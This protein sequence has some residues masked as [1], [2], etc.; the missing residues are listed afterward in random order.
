MSEEADQFQAVTTACLSIPVLAVQVDVS[1]EE[2]QFQAVT[3]ACLN[4]LILAVE[5]RLDVALQQM[6]RMP[7]ATLET[8]SYA[9]IHAVMPV[10]LPPL[11]LWLLHAPCVSLAG[12]PVIFYSGRALVNACRS[13]A[14]IVRGVAMCILARAAMLCWHCWHRTLTGNP[15]TM[16]RHICEASTANS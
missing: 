14:F 13:I 9:A 1:E 16:H 4:V 10:V 15:Q 8:V 7:W 6:T 2:D 3:T 12:D 5:T 11:C